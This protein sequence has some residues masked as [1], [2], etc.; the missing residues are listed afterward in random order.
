MIQHIYNIFFVNFC[1]KKFRVQWTLYVKELR[2]VENWNMRPCA[3]VSN[4]IIQSVSLRRSTRAYQRN[5]WK[6][7]Q[8]LPIFWCDAKCEKHFFAKCLTV[9]VVY[10]T[11]ALF[12]VDA[13]SEKLYA[14]ALNNSQ[15]SL[16]K[17]LIPKYVR[18]SIRK[19]RSLKWK[20]VKW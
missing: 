5:I 14:Y 17:L 13:I 7:V 20:N 3:N 1:N 16:S 15:W 8:E 2:R 9:D 4:R 11:Y 19:D 18:F 12:A 10:A 6:G